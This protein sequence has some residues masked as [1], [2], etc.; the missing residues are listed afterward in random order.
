[1][2]VP[3]VRHVSEELCTLRLDVRAA[4][5]YLATLRDDTRDRIRETLRTRLVPS[6]DGSI[7]MTARAWAVQGTVTPKASMH[8]ARPDG[9]HPLV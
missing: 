4:P 9:L 7:A 5:T 3:D 8:P 1:M 2:Q 6:A